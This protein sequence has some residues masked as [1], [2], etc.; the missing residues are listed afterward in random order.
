PQGGRR[1]P[2]HRMIVG[3]ACHQMLPAPGVYDALMMLLVM[4]VSAWTTPLNLAMP[5][6]TLTMPAEMSAVL[7]LIVTLA[8]ALTVMSLVPSF[9]ELP[10]ASA[11]SIEPGPSLSVTFWPA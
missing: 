6:L 11:S 8:E 3:H 5:A 2:L 1:D 4:T 10:F 7:A 9:T